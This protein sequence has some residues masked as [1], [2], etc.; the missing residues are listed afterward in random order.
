MI[1]LVGHQAG[2]DMQLVLSFTSSAAHCVSCARTSLSCTPAKQPDSHSLADIAEGNI[3][4]IS[5]TVSSG[6]AGRRARSC[7]APGVYVA[8]NF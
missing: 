2:L 1:F 3:S 7:K 8:C 6:F 4:G 5:S